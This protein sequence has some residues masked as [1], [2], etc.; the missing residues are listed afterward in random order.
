[1]SDSI[2][3]LFIDSSQ[4]DTDPAVVVLERNGFSVEHRQVNSYTGFEQA[5]REQQWDLILCER[6]VPR[7]DALVAWSRVQQRCPKTPFV[8]LSELVYGEQLVELLDAGVEHFV[9][10]HR[11]EALAP[12]VRS[13]L[14]NRFRRGSTR[15]SG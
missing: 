4:P 14:G 11:M 7:L 10:K 5:L 2:N 3:V 1:M 13:V 6:N 8:V 12:K 15:Q 9:D